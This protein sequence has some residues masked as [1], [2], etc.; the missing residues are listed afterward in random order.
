MEVS[1]TTGSVLAVPAGETASAWGGALVVSH[2]DSD[3]KRQKKVQEEEEEE[4]EGL[5]GSSTEKATSE[6]R[7][8]YHCES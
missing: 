5:P 7:R 6:H 1:K 4:E 8:K 2:L 3:T